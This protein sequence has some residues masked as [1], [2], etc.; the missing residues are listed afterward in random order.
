MMSKIMTTM[1]QKSTNTCCW[2][3][4]DV[5]CCGTAGEKTNMSN[6]HADDLKLVIIAIVKHTTISKTTSYFPKITYTSWCQA[7]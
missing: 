1:L 7:V 3:A 6:N 5:S 4:V 2:T